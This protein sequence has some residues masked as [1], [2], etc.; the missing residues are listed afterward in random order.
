[1]AT[2]DYVEI[3][4]YATRLQDSPRQSHKIVTSLP[5]A[6]PNPHITQSP[7]SPTKAGGLNMFIPQILLSSTLHIPES[8]M[9]HNNF[10]TTSTTTPLTTGAS[11]RKLSPNVT[12]L[13]SRRDP[14]SIPTTTVNFKRFVSKSGPV[15]WFQDRV[16]EVVMW[17]RGWKVTGVWMCVYAF[18]CEYLFRFV[19]YSCVSL[20]LC[21]C[22]IG[23]L[24]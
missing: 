19:S 2:L 3:P 13:L 1:M 15:F 8:P 12:P 11:A 9:Q 4:P 22:V 10:S 18:L 24:I 17:R 21:Q 20:V 5:N 23:D 7:T 6:H 14:L 16:E